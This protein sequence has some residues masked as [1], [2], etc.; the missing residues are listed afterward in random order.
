MP[1][2]PATTPP[3]VSTASP[4]VQPAPVGDTTAVTDAVAVETISPQADPT[5]PVTVAVAA[6]PLAADIIE[7]DGDAPAALPGIKPL[8]IRPHGPVVVDDD[9][10]VKLPT[11]PAGF[12]AQKAPKL[13][14]AADD[15]GS[16]ERDD[17]AA[18]ADPAVAAPPL[19]PQSLTLPATPTPAAPAP[20]VAAA[21]ISDAPSVRPAPIS[22]KTADKPLPV[23]KKDDVVIA[24]IAAAAPAS[25]AE[26]A[27]ASPVAGLA[28]AHSAIAE[29][30]AGAPPPVFA[31]V[32]LAGPPAPQAAAP[33]AAPISAHQSV[34][35]DDL[36]VAG[37]GDSAW[38]DRVASDI[39][40]LAKGDAREAHMKINPRVLGDMSIRLDM[41]GQR[42]RVH[43]TVDTS[44]AQALIADAAPKLTALVQA[45]GLKLDG[46]TVDLNQQRRDGQ[47]GQAQQQQQSADTPTPFNRT[48]SE[49]ARLAGRTRLVTR[50]DRFA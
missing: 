45:N 22:A 33:T 3:T 32:L 11:L 35:L 39:S 41:D 48:T 13:P 10:S 27:P 17:E 26:A 34:A 8:T 43:F 38:L 15:A 28:T 9:E 49:A 50:T 37:A 23:T 5:A 42:T 16:D 18:D 36:M 30:A 14:V 2:L 7:V 12:I 1:V 46:T 29:A 44:Q 6:T 47:S 31:P 25:T 21:L 20:A 4:I 24:D 19:P 40:T